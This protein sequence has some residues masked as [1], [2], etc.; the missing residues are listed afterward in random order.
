MYPIISIQPP[1]MRVLGVVSKFFKMLS[2]MGAN[3]AP[4]Q[5]FTKVSKV[6]E[7]F[8]YGRDHGCQGLSLSEDEVKGPL[9]LID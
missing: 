1:Q 9:R 4:T 7:L 2:R 3:S 6:C 8:Q 5:S